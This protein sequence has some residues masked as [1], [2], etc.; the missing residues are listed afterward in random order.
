MAHAARH[1]NPGEAHLYG[2]T[3]W[4]AFVDDRL[5]R[6]QKVILGYIDGFSFST[7]RALR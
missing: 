2:K 6:T 3:P 7:R 4:H 1:F 5:T